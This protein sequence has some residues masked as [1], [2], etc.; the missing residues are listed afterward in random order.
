MSSHTI[1][2]FT[3]VGAGAIGDVHARAIRSLPDA[4]ALSLIVSTREASAH[5]LA[6]ARGAGGYSTD[7]DAVLADPD[8]DAV[9]ICTPTGL[10]AD[11]AVAALEAGKHVMIEKPIDGDGG[12]TS[13]ARHGASSVCPRFCALLVRR[14]PLPWPWLAL[15]RTTRGN[16]QRS[17][18]AAPSAHDEIT[19]RTQVLVPADDDEAV[20]GTHDL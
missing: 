5:R 8:I 7:L 9:S 14:L 11:Q 4:A 6:E 20:A 17:P 15:P 3:V 1:V 16:W 10:H 18:L 13:G 2:R 12:T 19:E